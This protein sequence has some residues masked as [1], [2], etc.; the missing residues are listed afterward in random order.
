M[1]ARVPRAALAVL[2]RPIGA[3]LVAGAF[4]LAGLYAIQRGAALNSEGLS[5]AYASDAFRRA[6]LAFT[7]FLR[8]RPLSAALYAPFA[9]ISRETFFAAHVV[10]AALSLPMLASIARTLGLRSANVPSILVATSLAFFYSANS[11]IPTSDGL[12]GVTLFAWL[13]IVRQRPLASGLVLGA[14]PLARPE[15]LLLAVIVAGW[16]LFDRPRRPLLLG[17]FAVPFVYVTAGALYHHDAI[18][19]LHYAPHPP[20]GAWGRGGIDWAQEKANLTFM[21]LVDEVVACSPFFPLALIGAFRSKPGPMRALATFTVALFVVLNVLP[22]IQ[23]FTGSGGRYF[24]VVMP[25]AALFAAFLIEDALAGAPRARLALVAALLVAGAAAAALRRDIET[26]SALTLAVGLCAIGIP[27][28][29]APK[30]PVPAEPRAYG[31]AQIATLA[32]LLGVA[33]ASPFMLA[34]LD[35]AS[36][37]RALVKG[38]VDWLVAEGLPREDRIV[39]TNSQLLEPALEHA[40]GRPVPE[41]HFFF[42]D[43]ITRTLTTLTNPNNG[44]QSAVL[45]AL[46][47]VNGTTLYGDDL[48]LDDVPAG[49][50]FVLRED[51]RLWATIPEATWRPR[52]RQVH[53]EGSLAIYSFIPA[54]DLVVPGMARTQ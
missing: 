13:W 17:L 27:A 44:Q 15:L 2:E 52:L 3:W 43:D 41:V 31:H 6:P 24:V 36:R 16:T 34:P 28:L 8:L 50:L 26:V 38:A 51:R 46:R 14:L 42:Q 9:A 10:V 32:L 45:A 29:F 35:R 22:Q 11:G 54:S 33:A 37:E 47:S 7:F 20:H 1:T 53:G 5:L 25:F 48:H 4:A 49:S 19:F 18:W 39:Y 12:A 40:R 30:G 23:L 21:R